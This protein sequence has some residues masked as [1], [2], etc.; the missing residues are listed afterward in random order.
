MRSW[1]EWTVRHVQAHA[2]LTKILTASNRA[3]DLIH[4]ILAFSRQTGMEP[5]PVQVNI[6]AQEVLKLLQASLPKTI[7]IE[8]DLSCSSTIKGDATQIHQVIMI[9]HQCGPGDERQTEGIIEGVFGR[10]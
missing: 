1:P 7:H 3:R 2:N 8:E 5:G 4:Q 6:I 10:S 9:L